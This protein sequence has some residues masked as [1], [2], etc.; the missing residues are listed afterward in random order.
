MMRRF[1][2]NFS[3]SSLLTWLCLLSLGLATGS[4]L[5]GQDTEKEKKERKKEDKERRGRQLQEEQED[6]Y[7]KWQKEDVVYILTDEERSVFNRLSNDDERDAFIEQFWR[8]RDPDPNTGINEFKEEHYRRIAYANEHFTSGLEGWVTDRGRIYITFGPPNTIDDHQGGR[9]RRRYDEGGG[10]T[11]VYAFQ[12]WFYTYIPG[13]G[14]GIEIEFVDPSK[15]GEYKIALRPSEKDALW[16]ID[17]AGMTA[18]E[19]F[20]EGAQ[21]R[22][23]SQLSDLA[24][25]NIGLPNEP[26]YMRGAQPFEKLRDYFLLSKPPKVMFGH[27]RGDV[28]TRLKYN[29]LPLKVTVGDYRVGD[30]A[31]LA[32]LTIRVPAHELTYDADLKEVDRAVIQVFGKVQNLSGR[33]VYEFEDVIAADTTKN[34]SLKAETNFL[35][36]KQLPL[37]PGRYKVTII[38][39]EESSKKIAV[40]VTSVQLSKVESGKL[41]TSTL[42]VA[43]GFASSGPDQTLSDPFMTPSGI[44]VYPN[45][46]QEFGVESTLALYAEAYE[47][48]V[49]QATLSPSVE[50][51]FVLM[52]DGERVKVEEPRLVQLQDRVIFVHSMNLKGFDAGRYQVLLELH[53]RISGQ[54]LVKRAP[55]KIS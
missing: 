31:F 53:D 35:Y 23:G 49:D 7:K 20:S 44:K 24:M 14:D 10:Y 19:L 3:K 41:A 42:V 13:I 25:R 9:Y 18:G 54:R 48:S 32:P 5:L 34:K 27:L 11:S 37:R 36:Q 4:P 17:G 16:T 6:Y 40:Q 15:T 45:V 47:L 50:A 28:D 8:R 1:K 43:D 12:R 22:N 55:F 21:D 30:D 29:P 38:M 51:H 46:T 2:S 39:E 52:R 33:V 26:L